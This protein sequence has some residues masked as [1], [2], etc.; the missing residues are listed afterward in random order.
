MSFRLGAPSIVST[1]KYI[2]FVVGCVLLTLALLLD[3][4]EF[5]PI[6]DHANL[7][8]HEA[9]HVFFSVLGDTMELYGGTLMQLIIPALA[10]GAFWR[11][12]AHVSV[13]VAVVWFFQNFFNIA[14]YMADARA[15][16]LPLVGGG[17]HD[18]TAILS[19]WGMLQHDTTLATVLRFAGWL[20]IF[21]TLVWITTRW[22]SDRKAG[23][24][25]LDAEADALLLEL[26]DGDKTRD[27]HNG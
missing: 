23:G 5:L 12:K 27:R 22:W 1:R 24:E 9:G 4:D 17:K 6:I 26:L 16:E 19:S 20:G 3:E 13:G 15:H 7:I 25:R 2:A 10:V 18:W 14:R 11:Q 21:L 8:F